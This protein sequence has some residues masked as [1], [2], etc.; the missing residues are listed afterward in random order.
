MLRKKFKDDDLKQFPVENVTWNDCQELVKRLNEKEK[1]KGYV[2]RLPTEAEWEYACRGGATTEEECSYHYYLA[3][4]TNELS[5]KQ[6]N[7]SD[8]RDSREENSFQ[9]G[10]RE[11]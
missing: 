6:A 5:W 7:F 9:W 3:K 1:R 4:P 8:D 10:G 2:Y 11:K